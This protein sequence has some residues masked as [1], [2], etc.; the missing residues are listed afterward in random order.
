MYK[1]KC[2]M[3]MKKKKQI[4]NQMKGYMSQQMMVQQIAATS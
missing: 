1:Q 2:L 3:A 4:E